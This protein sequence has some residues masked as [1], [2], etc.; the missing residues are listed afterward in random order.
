L[1]E[2]GEVRKDGSHDKRGRALSALHRGGTRN[3]KEAK[4]EKNRRL[5]KEE[6]RTG[7]EFARATIMAAD[8]VSCMKT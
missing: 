1:K 7:L 3:K 5:Q 6:I 2:R 4:G 8:T